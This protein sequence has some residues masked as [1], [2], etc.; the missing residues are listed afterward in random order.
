MLIDTHKKFSSIRSLNHHLSDYI[1]SLPHSKH[2]ERLYI[3]TKLSEKSKKIPLTTQLFTLPF[4]IF[5]NHSH[6]YYYFIFNEVG[7]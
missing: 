6:S 5:F 7:I 1:L 2:Y 3:E 4:I